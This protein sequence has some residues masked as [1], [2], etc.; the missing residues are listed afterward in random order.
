MTT[1][2]RPKLLLVDDGERYVE[3]AH[4]L[5]TDYDYA[6]RCELP[7]PCWTCRHR[8]GCTLTHAH[9]WGE[10]EQTL[11]R[12][13]DVDVVLLDVSFDIPEE[14]LL[15][16]PADRGDLERRRRLQGLAILA[17]LR[18]HR[19]SLP[20]VLMT[21]R[22]ELELDAADEALDADEY[23][24]LAGRDSF[25]AR[26]LGLLV[27][28]ILAR[29]T[30][31][32]AGR[33][34]WGRSRAMTKVRQDVLAL[35][36]SSLPM[37][38]L[39]ETGTGKS[40]LVEEV[41][42]PASGRRG[43]FVAVD[44]GAIPRDL[45]AAELFGTVR[46]AFS[47]AVDRVGRFEQASGGTLLLDEIGN[48]PPEAQR[49][50]LLALQDR[51]ITRLGEGRPR[52][53]D[54]KVVAATNRD[55]ARAVRQGAFRADLYARLNP[56]AQVRLPPLR[57]RI[58]DLD[59]LLE[60]FCERAFEA[61]ADRALLE[62]HVALLGLRGPARA[63][64]AIGNA[65]SSAPPGVT[66]VLSRSSYALVRKHPFPGN[67]RELAMLAANACVSA[68]T[69]SIAAARGGRR[70]RADDAIVPIPARRIRELLEHGW[71][72]PD[73][74]AHAPDAPAFEP[75]ESLKDLRQTQ[76]RALFARLHA[77]TGGDFE[78][79]ARRLLRGD[80]A[81]NARKVQLRFNQLGLRVRDES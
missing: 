70:P 16:H 63:R 73:D 14:R 7:G 33:Y 25:D 30:S 48:L 55:L 31:G 50:L 4:A 62:E 40:A 64:L 59:A 53:V 71:V 47:G 68:L 5:L 13:P 32:D 49:M 9:D 29:R 37:L 38:V 24:T 27:E 51:R 65:P 28:R 41:V 11:S 61:P 43:P 1:P 6:T 69:D 10:T 45:V 39:G 54:V 42:H 76:E 79:M 36:P 35:A 66:F 15:A 23:L 56:A 77:A 58:E 19:A 72:E 52:A 18:R 22:D 81:E 2:P 17:R 75:L 12:H 80:P 26:A 3:L 34:E 44:L 8:Q 74:D 21:S 60:R 67:V 78:A 20:V 57:E 46:G